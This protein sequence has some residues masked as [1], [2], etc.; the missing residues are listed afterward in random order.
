MKTL[1]TI[2]N[3]PLAHRL[4]WVLLHSLWQ[5]A[6]VGAGFGLARQALRRRR[7]EIRYAVGCV[8][9]ALLL[10]G[11]VVTL[12]VWPANPTVSAMAAGAPSSPA[13]HGPPARVGPSAAPAQL[14][15]ASG[16]ALETWTAS[17]LQRG[18][19]LCEQLSPLLAAAWVLGVGVCLWRLM[20]GCWWLRRLRTRQVELVARVWLEVLEDLRVRLAISRPVRLLQ[21]A[22]VEV[23]TVIGWI[24]PVILLPAATLAGLTPEQLEAILAHELAHVRR[25]D[26]LVNACQCVV[27]TLLFYHPVVWWVSRC[28]REER[29]HCCDDLVVRVCGNRVAYARA[30]ATLEESRAGQPRFAFAAGGAPLL[31][32]IRRLLGGASESGAVAARQLCGL[33]LLFLGLALVV[34]GVDLL[35]FRADSYE[36][37]ARLQVERDQSDFASLAQGTPPV[38]V[39]DPYFIPTQLQLIQS[40]RVL[41]RVIT[42]LNLREIWGRRYANG[43]KLSPLEAIRRLKG[44]TVLRAIPNTHLIEIQAFDEDRDAAATLANVIAEAYREFRHEQR[45]QLALGGILALLEE[46]GQKEEEIA[47]AQ[48]NVDRLRKVLNIPDSM[49]AGDTPAPLLPAETMRRLSEQRLETEVEFVKQ[50]ALVKRLRAMSRAELTQA[51]PTAAQDNWLGSLLEQKVLADQ[52]LLAAQKDYGPNHAEVVKAQ[53]QVADLQDK[54]DKRV[55]GIMVGLS[56]KAEAL[57]EALT[58][59]VNQVDRA[60]K[61]DIDKANQ[62]APYFYAKRRLE[63]LQQFRR[64]LDTKIQSEKVDQRLPRTVMVQIMDYAMRP[65]RPV[66]PNRSLGLALTAVGLLVG[67]LGL[68]LV[69]A[70]RKAAG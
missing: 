65:E 24:R 23:P 61:E 63:E 39:D 66:S 14:A 64:L 1:L 22:L 29:E 21:S 41:G 19:D 34:L 69:R 16:S 5:G 17:L 11:P 36:A 47:K 50:D 46:R 18:G 51:L 25:F 32:R 54:I 38:G 7:P 44:R 37:V 40:Q 56:A 57:T 2:L 28:V 53:S 3:H 68:V 20:R 15:L 45:A 58:N 31:V 10:A 55:E 13:G 27:E 62:S 70:E 30:L 33:G 6:L 8:A 43:Q 52:R 35:L 26:Y 48:T 49:M 12:F 42:N 9:L 4:G 67:L 59:L 60:I